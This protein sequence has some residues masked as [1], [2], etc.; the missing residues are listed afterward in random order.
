[1]SDKVDKADMATGEDLFEAALR[2]AV[3]ENHRREMDEL[4]T[5]EELAKTH[6]FS[7]DHRRKM[8]ALFRKAERNDVMRKVL[9]YAKVAVI[10]IAVGATVFFCALLTSSDARAAI[11]DTVTK[12]YESI[13]K[14]EETEEPPP[15]YGICYAPM[16]V[17][18]GFAA[19]NVKDWGYHCSID[20][21]GESDEKILFSYRT[22]ETVPYVVDEDPLY[23]TVTKNG[24]EYR[25][26]GTPGYRESSSI[27]WDMH[28]YRFTVTSSLDIGEL[29]MMA[30]SV[31]SA[32]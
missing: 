8:A 7:E 16:Y 15:N 22:L 25:F 30:L 4:P 27:V 1:M 17:P 19:E 10:V 18:N 24:I 11:T 6:E 31:E 5:N 26:L 9:G 32:G 3:V 21:V 13:A 29:F 12:W 14:P 20:F 28:G 23:G 2:Q